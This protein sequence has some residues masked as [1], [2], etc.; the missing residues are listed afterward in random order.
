MIVKI[1]ICIFVS[2]MMITI[3]AFLVI[4]L[5]VIICR[6]RQNKDMF[7]SLQD[8]VSVLE[9]RIEGVKAKWMTEYKKTIVLSDRSTLVHYSDYL[10]V[11]E[12]AKNAIKQLYDTLQ[13]SEKSFEKALMTIEKNDETEKNI[14][15]LMK[16][17]IGIKKYNSVKN[18]FILPNNE[19]FAVSQI[20]LKTLEHI[21]NVNTSKKSSDRTDNI[22]IYGTIEQTRAAIKK[23][24][25]WLNK[26]EQISD[27]RTR[28]SENLETSIS[29]VG[30]LSEKLEKLLDESG[31]KQ[32]YNLQLYIFILSV[33]SLFSSIIG[34]LCFAIAYS[35]ELIPE[36]MWSL[37]IRLDKSS[38]SILQ[39][40]SSANLSVAGICCLVVLILLIVGAVCLLKRLIK[41]CINCFQN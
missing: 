2:V 19:I 22:L 40:Y 21:V 26:G 8:K 34:L 29:D 3:P 9:K 35:C 36:N 31:E 23:V 1:F 39:Q 15:S 7:K 32:Q 10:A 13:E 14:K 24:V 30:S 4:A 37:F 28:I 27:E 18:H 38:L 20:Q 16:L 12:N 11:D 25:D 33:V 5:F 6:F 41:K 17:K